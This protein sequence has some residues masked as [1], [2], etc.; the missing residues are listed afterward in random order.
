MQNGRWFAGKQR[1]QMPIRALLK[2]L[3]NLSMKINPESRPVP[4]DAKQIPVEFRP[5]RE[6]A[7]RIPGEEPTVETHLRFSRTCRDLL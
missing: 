7:T 5:I 1:F 6:A 3:S 2:A 4:K